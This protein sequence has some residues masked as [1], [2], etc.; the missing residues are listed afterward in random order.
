[1]R[2]KLH[3][4]GDAF[5]AGTCNLDAVTSVVLRG[6]SKVLPINTVGG[7]GT[8]VSR[9]FVDNDSGAGRC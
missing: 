4:F 7:P 8:A 1:M 5:C 9:C 6:G 3:S 2:G